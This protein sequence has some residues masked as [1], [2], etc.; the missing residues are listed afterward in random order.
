[1][2]ISPESICRRERG[3]ADVAY[4]HDQ[5]LGLPEAGQDGFDPVQVGDSVQADVRRIVMEG[6]EG[7]PQ[8]AQGDPG[9][10]AGGT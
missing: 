7:N 9:R 2:V 5:R 4:L 3:Q 6:G 8:H 10:R 1:M